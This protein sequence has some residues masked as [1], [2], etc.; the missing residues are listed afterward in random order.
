VE[1]KADRD[2]DNQNVLNKEKATLMAEE[3]E[4][5]EADDK[6]NC[7]WYYV[8]LGETHFIQRKQWGFCQDILHLERLTRYMVEVICFLTLRILYVDII[9]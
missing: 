5:S 7:K 3:R 9:V 4:C 6:M 2:M 8:L 1:T